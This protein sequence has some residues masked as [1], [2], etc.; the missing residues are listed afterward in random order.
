MK[1]LGF[2]VTKFLIPLV[3]EHF[4]LPYS[5]NLQCLNVRK[6]W[7]IFLKLVESSAW[8]RLADCTLTVYT[9]QC[10]TFN[11]ITSCVRRDRA[12]VTK[13]TVLPQATFLISNG[14][15]TIA[16]NFSHF[17]ANDVNRQLFATGNG[18]SCV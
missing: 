9:A 16:C 13:I 11:T 6:M 5:P 4:C 1:F 14:N 17:A 15:N 7:I 3:I 2:V 10:W 8:T 18:A 12:L